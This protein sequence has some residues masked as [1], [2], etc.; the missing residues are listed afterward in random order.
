MIDYTPI[1]FD[2]K[3]L[4]IKLMKDGSEMVL[5]G[6]MKQ[7]VMKLLL[8]KEEERKLGK[9]QQRRAISFNISS[10]SAYQVS[11]N[12]GQISELLKSFPDVF[13]IPESLLP[14]REQDHSIPLKPEV[15]QFKL[16]PY[17]YPHSP[18]IRN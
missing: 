14:I 12:L 5:E 1:T 9:L 6:M 2:F 8:D 18:K 3:Q 13:E 15:Q 16:K 4:Q 11:S 7:P 10:S 17:R